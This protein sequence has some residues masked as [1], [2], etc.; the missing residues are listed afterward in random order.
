MRHVNPT[1]ARRQRIELKVDR[2]I[3]GMLANARKRQRR[4]AEHRRRMDRLN[5]FQEANAEGIVL[6]DDLGTLRRRAAFRV[7]PWIA[8]FFETYVGFELMRTFLAQGFNIQVVDGPRILPV[9]FTILLLLTLLLAAGLMHAALK[10]VAASTHEERWHGQAARLLTAACLLLVIPV[11]SFMTYGKDFFDAEGL[12]SLST[13]MGLS[14]WLFVAATLVILMLNYQILAE[15][16]HW[17]VI[18][19]DRL[20]RRHLGKLQRAARRSEGAFRRLEERHHERFAQLNEMAMPLRGLW[21]SMTEQQRRSAICFVHPDRRFILNMRVFKADVLP[22]EPEVVHA[23]G[24]GYGKDLELFDADLRNHAE[25]QALLDD[26]QETS[27]EPN[28]GAADADVARME[29]T[30]PEPDL[31][32]ANTDAPFAMQVPASEQQAL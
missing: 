28:T 14:K 12:K 6:S 22:T 27:S 7:K 30:G 18:E 19:D 13:L 2:H 16:E 5:A 21:A 8:V 11:L 25:S 3:S 32:D 23:P 10:M 17:G 31:N 9:P 1:E 24:A 26:E 4:A 20:L 15:A 29:H